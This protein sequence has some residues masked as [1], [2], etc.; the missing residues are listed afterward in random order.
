M[1]FGEIFLIGIGLS[2]DAVAVSITN[3]M[4]YPR[5]GREK[6]LTQPLFFGVFQ[7]VMPLAGYY[8]GGLFSE[9]IDRYAGLVTL[10][11][12]GFIGGKMI[13]DAFH[14]D[15]ER[16]GKGCL[17]YRLLLVQSVA[18]SIDAF[19]VGVSFSAMRVHILP[20]VLTI[21]ATTFV[22]SLAATLLGKKCGDA[23]GAKAQLFGGAVLVLIG[24][25]AML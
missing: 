16:E 10:L 21:G 17:T 5:A 2:M 18:T 12:L 25:K 11:I 9:I 7:A 4:A 3:G 23:L 22:C 8:A 20:S 13:Y 15:P 6:G 24:I 14:P 1:S 19:A